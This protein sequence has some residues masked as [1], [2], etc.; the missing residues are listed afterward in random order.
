[1][2]LSG[3]HFLSGSAA[4]VL[5]A[6]FSVGLASEASAALNWKVGT[7]VSHDHVWSNVDS[8]YMECV[9]PEID[10]PDAVMCYRADRNATYVKSMKASGY[11]KLG[12]HALS[13][14]IWRC[15]NNYRNS[16]GNG[17]WVECKWNTKPARGTCPPIR[18]GHGLNDWYVMSNASLR[19]CFTD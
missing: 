2:R 16:S 6:S 7:P 1:M 5:A 13:G 11:F 8:D 12:Q 19:I 9:G 3:R 14:N 15:Q 18:V 17:T 10:I 4:V